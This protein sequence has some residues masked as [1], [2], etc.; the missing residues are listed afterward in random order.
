LSSSCNKLCFSNM[1][2]S[3]SV[4]TKFKF[5]KMFFFTRLLFIEL[6]INF[7]EFSFII[8]IPN[9]FYIIML[10]YDYI[11]CRIF[12]CIFCKQSYPNTPPLL[13]CQLPILGT[14]VEAIW[15]SSCEPECHKW[16]ICE[17]GILLERQRTFVW[18]ITQLWRQFM[19]TSK[20]KV[21]LS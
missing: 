19:A 5:L 7:S 10:F 3:F 21:L 9:K 11:S 14:F 4:H 12:W 20:F 13:F 17:A 8:R 16:S 6:T 1:T 18:Q 2:M 15:Q